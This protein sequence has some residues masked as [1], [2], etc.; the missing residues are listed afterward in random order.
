MQQCLYPHRNPATGEFCRSYN[1]ARV[2]DLYPHTLC[3]HHIGVMRA[4]EEGETN[5]K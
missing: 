2:P 1:V 3:A 4:E 5:G